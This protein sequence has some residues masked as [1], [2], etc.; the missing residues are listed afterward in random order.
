MIFGERRRNVET[1]NVIT[2]L[3]EEVVL[4]KRLAFHLGGHG[5]NLYPL[6][7]EL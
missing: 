1:R 3:S 7:T 2:L 6:G 4:M 5:D